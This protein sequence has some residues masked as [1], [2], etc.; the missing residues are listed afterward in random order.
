MGSMY[1]QWEQFPSS[2]VRG[3]EAGQVVLVA[4]VGTNIIPHGYQA[5]KEWEELEEFPVIPVHEP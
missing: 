5:F 4:D 2:L 1:N 3:K